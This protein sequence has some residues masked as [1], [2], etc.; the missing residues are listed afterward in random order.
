[1]IKFVYFDIGDVIVDCSRYFE[2]VCADYK[3]D[4][5]IFL[6]FYVKHKSDLITGKLKTEKFWE[7]CVNHFGLERVDDYNFVKS[8]VLDY[9][10][11]ESVKDLILKMENFVNVGIISNINSGVWEEMVSVGL[12]PKIKSEK[13]LLSCNLGVKKPEKEIYKME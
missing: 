7:E 1:M 2:S 5:E 11:V 4:F 9:M 10:P 12:V 8:W 6:S 13:V 3:L